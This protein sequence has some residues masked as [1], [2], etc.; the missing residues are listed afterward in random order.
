MTKLT[1]TLQFE[2]S[3]AERD[4]LAE[5]F[6]G[7][8][9]EPERALEQTL[10]D[11]RRRWRQGA[12]AAL[13]RMLSS[14][15][16]AA[17]PAIALSNLPYDRSLTHGLADPVVAVAAKPDRLSEGLILGASQDR[18]LPY[19]VATEGNGLVVNLSP[20]REQTEAFTGLGSERPLGF[21]VE[22]AG[23]AA[24]RQAP[25]GLALIGVHGD[26]GRGPA[27]FVADVA[28]AVASLPPSMR[29]VLRDP[30]RFYLRLPKRWRQP[31]RRDGAKGAVL[32]GRLCQW[33]YSFAFYSDMTEGLDAEARQ[34][35]AALESALEVVATP[36]WIEPGVMVLVNNR[37]AAHGRSAFKSSYTP[38]GVPLRW[39]QRVFWTDDLSVFH[40]WE[41]RGP[42]VF[43]PPADLLS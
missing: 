3:D 41:T 25:A 21:H 15:Q 40:R 16:A 42:R 7:Y 39:L 43:A 32:H 22:H 28:S 26:A 29:R 23:V 20:V 36:T 37:R 35:L 11:A 5:A 24:R 6:D 27:T 17:A 18:G 33:R 4:R 14:P 2:L 31:G 19:G 8:V 9:F 1:N 30:E 12:P 38:D 10:R 13:T 34:A